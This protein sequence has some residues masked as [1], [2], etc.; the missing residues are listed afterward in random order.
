M[1]EDSRHPLIIG[2]GI[3]GLFVAL[4]SRELG[5]HPTVVTKGRLDESNT[6]YAQG[7][8]AAAIGEND[9]VPL[10]YRDTM[11]AGDGLADPTAVGMLTREA[12]ARI[13]DLVRYG[14]P[15]DT[16]EG[17]IA[18]GQ[19]AAHSRPRVLHAGGDATGLSIEETLRQRAMDAGIELKERSVLR[20]LRLG[21]DG[22]LEAALSAPEG[23]RLEHVS[24]RPIVL[25]TGGAGN[26]FRFS[27]NPAVATGDGVAI[28][29][30]AGALLTDME[31]VQFHPTAFFREGAPRFLISEAVRGEGAVLRTASGD[32]FMP[33]FHPDAELAPRD[34]VTRAIQSELTRTGDPSVF[35]DAT[36]IP[37]ERLFTR[38]PTITRFLAGYQ[39]DPSTDWIPVTPVAHYMIGGV[40]SDHEGRSSLPGLYV[41]GE[42]AATRVHGA[43]RLASNSLL[44]GLVFG[45]HVVRQLLSPRAG[46]PPR[47]GRM[48]SVEWPLGRGASLDVKAIDEVRRILWEW[49]GIVRTPAQLRRAVEELYSIGRRYEPTHSDTPANSAAHAALVGYLIVRAARARVESRG[50][51]YRTDHPRPRASWRLHLG[52]QRALARSHR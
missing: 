28:A 46:A 2:S 41:C 4:R 5:L 50:S 49:V 23:R 16:V 51:H 34:V 17:R 26:L 42:V 14:V 37:R 31:F 48:L 11:R 25:A 15:F 3:A 27:S 38:F 8:I 6:R 29:F 24:D 33:R 7:G 52:I 18:L 40:A 39:V 45:E 22:R 47:P 19:E 32:R 43:N 30:R 36:K 20:I 44:E 9:A 21:P 1:P 13:A 12:P 10:H 35:L